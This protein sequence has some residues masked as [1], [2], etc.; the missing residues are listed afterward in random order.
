[1]LKMRVSDLSSEKGLTLLTACEEIYVVLSST[2]YPVEVVYGLVF[3]TVAVFEKTTDINFRVCPKHRDSF[4]IKWRG[5]KKTSF[6]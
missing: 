5:R 2:S 3:Y 1:M 4:G 6:L